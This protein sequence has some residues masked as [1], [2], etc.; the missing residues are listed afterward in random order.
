MWLNKKESS[1]GQRYFKI[2][3]IPRISRFLLL[4]KRFNFLCWETLYKE[5]LFLTLTNK[6]TYIHR[7]PLTCHAFKLS[8][9]HRASSLSCRVHQ[10]RGGWW[11]CLTF[12]LIFF[13]RGRELPIK[14]HWNL[15]GYGTFHDRG[16]TSSDDCRTVRERY[17]RLWACDATLRKSG[18]LL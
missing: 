10:R 1:K 5:N 3:E 14:G 18:R 9:I 16:Q 2:P 11:Q 7:R 13:C 8:L 4:T 12:L 6:T 17:C 15:Y